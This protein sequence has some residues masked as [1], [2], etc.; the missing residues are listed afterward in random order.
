MKRQFRLLLT[1]AVLLII[2][3]GYACAQ[4][5][6]AL[7]IKN[8]VNLRAAPIIKGKIQCHVYK[9]IMLEVIG[10]EKDWIKVKNFQG[11]SAYVNASLV[12]V[13]K[14]SPIPSHLFKDNSDYSPYG[15]IRD[16]RYCCGNL[17]IYVKGNYIIF[18]TMWMRYDYDSKCDRILPAEYNDI[19]AVKSGGQVIFKYFLG[20]TETSFNAYEWDPA[21]VSAR[22]LLK[23]GDIHPIGKDECQGI[24]EDDVVFYNEEMKVLCIG[25]V[26]YSMDK[27]KM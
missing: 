26:A 24:K 16:D 6:K 17:T 1:M 9:G 14:P 7:I 11:E 15:D 19:I 5:E 20:Y 25:H 23:N 22:E 27:P 13:L 3:S 10:R 2:I 21:T 18:S 8:K 12:K 4:G